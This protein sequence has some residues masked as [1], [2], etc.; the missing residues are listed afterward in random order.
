MRVASDAAVV[1]DKCDAGCA[2]EGYV[3]LGNASGENQ[4]SSCKE[5]AF[6]VFPSSC[7]PN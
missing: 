1:I 3:S 6:H 4:R 7:Y 5:D 2:G